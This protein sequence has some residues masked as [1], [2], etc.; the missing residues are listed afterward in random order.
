MIVCGADGPLN[1]VAPLYGDVVT[2]DKPL[3]FYRIHGRN[4]GAQGELTAEKFSRFILHDQNRI[5]YLREHALRR[6]CAI[7]GE[8]LDRAVL[9]LQYRIASLRLK[10]EDHPI[11]GDSMRRILGCAAAALWQTRERGLSRLFL[12]SWFLAVAAAPR[13]LADWLVALRFVPKS[14][15]QTLA[16]AMRRLRVLRSPEDVDPSDL[17]LPAPLRP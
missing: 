4:D 13:R 14:R 8:P 3:G 2:I 12:Y 10:P 17:S 6:G 1:T 11:V 9:N 15:P 16:R 7:A 5:A